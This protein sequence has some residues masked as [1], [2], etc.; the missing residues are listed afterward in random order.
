MLVL[1]YYWSRFCV[2]LW[3]LKR[4]T[5]FTESFVDRHFIVVCKTVMYNWWTVNETNRPAVYLKSIKHCN[6]SIS[7]H[8]WAQRFKRDNFK[9][10]HTKLLSLP[11]SRKLY[12]IQT[13][14]LTNFYF[15]LVFHRTSIRRTPIRYPPF[16]F[17]LFY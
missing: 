1:V 13:V 11:N 9:S 15:A 4:L 5:L 16:L 10:R 7:F 8:F 12:F 6:Q 2:Q 3:L 14:P 17:S